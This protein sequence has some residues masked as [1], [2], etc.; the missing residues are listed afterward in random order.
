MQAGWDHKYRDGNRLLD[1]EIV[2][3]K[4]L[5]TVG[6]VKTHHDRD[7]D[8]GIGIKISM[9]CYR[10]GGE[11]PE[12]IE[13]RGEYLG[14]GQSKTAFELHCSGAMFHGKV[15]KA[16]KK[17]DTEPDVFREGAPF[18]FTTRIYYDC[19]GVDAATGLRFHCWITDRT[20]PLDE[21]CRD[22]VAIRSRCSLAAFH[23]MLRAALHGLYLSDC[24]FF[25]FGVRLSENATEHIVVI[26]DAGSRGIHRSAQWAKSVMNTKVM[27]KFWKACDEASADCDELKDMW[28]DSGDVKLC[29]Q[30]ATHKWEAWPFL[31]DTQESSSALWQSMMSKADFRRSTAHSTST[32]KLMELVGRFGAEEEWSPACFWECYRASEELQTQLFSEE[33]SILDELY[34]RIT[35]KRD[36]DEELHDVMQF[37]GTLDRHRQRQCLR[38]IQCPA[39]QPV[40]PDQATEI[41]ESFKYFELWYDLTERQRRS[42]PTKQQSLLNTILHRRAGWTHAARAIMQYGLPRL[43]QPDQPDDATGHVNALG[44]FAR[45]MAKWLLNFASAMHTYR[46]TDEYQRNYQASM[47]ALEKRK[48]ARGA[49]SSH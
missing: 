10:A 34:S 18:G 27:R 24:H 9:P 45:D 6:R 5:S 42:S 14:H 33:D 17:I 16:A 8:V 1:P 46:Q 2:L 48:R 25:N 21:F 22:K 40:T 26:I 12:M 38:R 7:P 35:T 23:C 13:Y 36:R 20:I 4:D 44:Q 39:N 37:W 32:Y 49:T 47:A 19:D 11:T 3:E 30:R 43:E 29:W 31:S 28:R 41:L 15:L